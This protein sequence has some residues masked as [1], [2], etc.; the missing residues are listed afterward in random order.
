MPH[1]CMWADPAGMPY[2][3]LLIVIALP[4]VLVGMVAVAI[5]SPTMLRYAHVVLGSAL[6]LLTIGML[7][8]AGIL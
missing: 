5:P 1:S 4:F 6:C 7:V 2:T 3:W 8:H